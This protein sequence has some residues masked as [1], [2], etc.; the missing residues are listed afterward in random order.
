MN[1]IYVWVKRPGSPP[2]HVWVSD[3][4]NNLQKLVGGYIETVTLADDLVV[5]CNEEGRL[6]GLPFNFRISE[7]LSFVG[8]VVFV[9]IKGEEFADC[10][11]DVKGMKKL[12]PQL[13]DVMAT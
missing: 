6:K 7:T 10:P 8:D 1:K 2:R 5:I 12:F 3:T 9:G 11:L 13:W 4:L